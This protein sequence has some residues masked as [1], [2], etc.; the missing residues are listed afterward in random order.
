MANEKTPLRDTAPSTPQRAIKSAD[1]SAVARRRVI[2]GVVVAIVVIGG[3]Y[4]LFGGKD[5]PISIPNFFSSSPPVPA[6]SFTSVRSGYEATVAGADKDA[7]AATAKDLAPKV[8]DTVTTLFQAGYVDPSSWGDAGAIEDLFTDDAKGQL[9]ANIDVLTLGTTAG[10]V[11][12]A[13]QPSTSSLKVVALTDAKGNALR[14]EALPVFVA[15]ATH[16]D[17][18]FSEITVTG[19]LFLVHDGNEWRIEA[20]SLNRDEKPAEAPA[21]SA[22]VSTSASESP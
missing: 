21:P 5:A 22:S 11:Y 1:R 17:G 19:T 15:I 7:Q 13:L 10:D 20:F 12:T 18:T 9:D 6:F 8:E 14:A 2:I 16:A 3:L 4:L